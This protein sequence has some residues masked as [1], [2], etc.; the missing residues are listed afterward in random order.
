ML[1][2]ALACAFFLCLHLAIAG[3]PVKA[4]LIARAG[5]PVYYILFA[6]ASALGLV[7]MVYA[8]FGAMG[9]P[10]N[11]QLWHAPFWLKVL[12]LVSNFLSILL[13]V[14]GIF[15]ASPVPR[16]AG[17]TTGPITGIIRVTRHP[18]LAGIA[19]LALTHMVCNG[20]L[21]SW[22]FF[23]SVLSLCVLGAWNLDQKREDRL[24]TEYRAFIGK[25]SFIPFLAIA[26]RRNRFEFMELGLAQLLL[27][28]SV[29]AVLVVLHELL[30]LRPA[31]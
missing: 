31:L 22:I 27:G 7:W 23:G 26:Q 30:F 6:F 16:K 17:A 19:L 13:I 8:Y 25:T 24:G 4:H 10:L 5:A 21:A 15:S 20:N 1:L 3:T 14:V 18:L 29:F 12:A 28:T 2:L 11:L 9:D